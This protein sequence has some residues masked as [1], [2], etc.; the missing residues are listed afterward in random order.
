MI[1][2]KISL[3][4]GL[5]AMIWSGW[6]RG[7]ETAA[8]AELSKSV[9]LDVKSST[10]SSTLAA[11]RDSFSSYYYKKQAK[12]SVLEVSVRNMSPLPGKFSLEWYFFG[13][14]T[15]G[16]KRFLFD[17]G[18]KDIEL[19]P[20]AFTKIELESDELTSSRARSY[21]GYYHYRS[22]DKADGWAIRALV[23]KEVVR[24]KASNPNYER[25]MEDESELA[26][27]IEKEQ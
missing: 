12:S 24:I 7:Q 20:G 17:R 3:W 2:L 11:S 25:I 8:P 13:R 27:Y 4:A 18:Q 14:P 10:S 16:S 5:L 9:Y 19:K 1:G 23:G 6:A 26:R 22:G 15:S 21:Y